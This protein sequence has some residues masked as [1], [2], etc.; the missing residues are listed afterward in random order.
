MNDSLIHQWRIQ[1]ECPWDC[2]PLSKPKWQNSDRYLT[3]KMFSVVACTDVWSPAHEF[4]I[5]SV[6]GK[7]VDGTGLLTV[8]SEAGVI[9]IRPC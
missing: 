6:K 5:E 2:V 1:S 9:N 7:L 4:V 8:I 3:L